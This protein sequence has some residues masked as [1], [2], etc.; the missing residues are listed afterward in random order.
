MGGKIYRKTNMEYQCHKR[1]YKHSIITLKKRNKR[2]R[3]WDMKKL[4]VKKDEHEELVRE[5]IMYEVS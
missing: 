1:L 2:N 4:P 3:T 5:S